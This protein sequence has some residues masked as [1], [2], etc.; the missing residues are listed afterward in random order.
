MLSNVGN[1][2]IPTGRSGLNMGRLL[3]GEPLFSTRARSAV[4]SGCGSPPPD[5][6]LAKHYVRGWRPA[7]DV[8]LG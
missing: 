1:K 2:Y 5:G 3:E 8:A 4:Y 6:E 7:G